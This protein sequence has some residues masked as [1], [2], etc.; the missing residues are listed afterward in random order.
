MN[1]SRKL[2]R[3]PLWVGLT[4]RRPELYRVQRKG[5][6]NGSPRKKR[7]RRPNRPGEAARREADAAK[8][9][10]MC[11]KRDP[12]RLQKAEAEKSA[13]LESAKS[14]LEQV[15]RELAEL[16][17]G[18]GCLRIRRPGGRAARRPMRSSRTAPPPLS[19]RPTRGP[20]KHREPGRGK[21]EKRSVRRRNRSLYKVQAGYGRL[22]GDVDATTLRLR[23][24][25]PWTGR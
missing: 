13:S 19:W 25:G 11:W 8:G 18:T 1:S 7:W 21:G 24:D 5:V 20:G 4:V 17:K 12:E 3:P 15:R 2:F 9:A 6:H 16:R 23:R 10:R 14:D 22:R